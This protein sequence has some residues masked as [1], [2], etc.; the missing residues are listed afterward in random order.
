MV[1]VRLFSGHTRIVFLVVLL[2]LPFAPPVA[3]SSGKEEPMKTAAILLL[4]TSLAATAG[5]Q[6]AGARPLNPIGNCCI[7]SHIKEN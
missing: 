2:H 5:A 4:L 1:D 6:S 3:S 7:Q